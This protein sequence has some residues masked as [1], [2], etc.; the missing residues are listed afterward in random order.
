M[1]DRDPFA[2]DPTIPLHYCDGANIHTSLNTVTIGFRRSQSWLTPPEEM[3]V[4]RVQLSP[5][6]LKSI[7]RV[8]GDLLTHY[9]QT[10]GIIPFDPNAI[11]PITVTVDKSGQ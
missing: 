2:S 6:T 9:E 11:R 10:Y 7:H 1:S 8:I 3:D 5:T 4:V